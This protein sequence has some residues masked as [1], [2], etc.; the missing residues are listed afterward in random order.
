MNVRMKTSAILALI[1][2]AGVMAQTA[3]DVEALL[4][5]ISTYQYGGDP[6]P[7]IRFEEMVAKS[8]GSAEKRK[9]IEGLLLKFLQ[10]NATP[11][12]KEAAF[13]QLSIVGTS[14][15]VPV[16]APLSLQIDTAEMA[17]YALAAIPGSEVDEALRKGLAAAPSDR[18]R[19]GIINSLGR[20]K[21]TK[22]VSALTALIGSNNTEVIA[23]AAA[24]LASIADRPAV[25]ALAAARRKATGPTRGI[26]SEA[27][28]VSGDRLAERGEKAQAAAVYKEM[29]AAQ[30]SNTIRA[31][32]LRGFAATDVKSA[33]PALIAE[34]GTKDPERQVTAIRLLNGIQGGDAT[35]ALIAAFPNVSAVARVHLLTAVASRGDASARQMVSSAIESDD[36]AVR[37][38]ALAALGKLGDQSSVKLLA[39]AAAAGQGP[40]SAAARQSLY[41]LRGSGI[42]PAIVTA[43]RSSSGKMKTELIIAAGERAA[44]S[45]A[46]ALTRAAQESDPEV[47]RE[48]LRALRNVGGAGQTQSLLDVLLKASSTSERR[49]ATQTLATVLKRAQPAPLGSIVSAYNTTQAREARLSL[50]EVMG[51]TSSAEVL[52][53]LRSSLKDPDPEIARA[54]ILALTA[55]DDATPLPDLLSVA[56]GTPRSAGAEPEPVAAGPGRGLGRGALPPT[57]NL[58][59][60]ALRGVLKLILLP[61]KRTP[62]ENGQL[63]AEAMRLASQV[64]EKRTILSLLPTF[65]S[66]ETL[67]IAQTATDAAIANEARV[68]VDQVTE[69]L[70]IK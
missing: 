59:I 28:L 57:N 26:V 17:R 50:L 3:A 55:W 41:T 39:E 47:R 12:G 60:L 25:D 37:A 32:A 36:A 68:A 67:Q 23:A 69:A 61:S 4:A 19:I 34:T 63:L 27:Y 6:A 13:R 70:K 35:K 53:L 10:S 51:Q 62:A 65:P 18:I 45:A 9:M 11:A 31:R 54:A 21:D 49:D 2:A 15:S 5:K 48:A 42:D 29:I 24:A 58:Q 8:S 44:I 33:V 22:A 40:E 1:A 20:R 64:P 16:L 30:D 56:K 7:S 43:I 52:P 66:K 38:A 46:D 14:A